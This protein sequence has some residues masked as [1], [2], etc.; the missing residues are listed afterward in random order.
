MTIKPTLVTAALAGLFSGTAWPLLWP[1]LGEPA[2]S[3]TINL[4]VATVLLVALPVHAFVVGFG[5]RPGGPGGVDRA[6]LVRTAVWLAA[7]A[8][9]ALVVAGLRGNG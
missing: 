9:A 3:D 7:A 8:G 4:L 1:L 2:G 6:L 5:A